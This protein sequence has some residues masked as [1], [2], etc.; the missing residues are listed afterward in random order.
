MYR[1]IGVLIPILFFALLVV[2]PNIEGGS[3]RGRDT[4]LDG[5]NIYDASSGIM[6][7]ML[8]A[9]WRVGISSEEIISMNLT[10]RGLIGKNLYNVTDIIY[11]MNSSSVYLY[12]IKNYPG[13]RFIYYAT[14]IGVSDYNVSGVQYRNITLGILRINYT[15]NISGWDAKPSSIEWVFTNTTTFRWDELYS[16]YYVAPRINFLKTVFLENK[17]YIIIYDIVR[18]AYNSTLDVIVKNTTLIAYRF[19]N[20]DTPIA[21]PI[22]KH[23][24]FLGFVTGITL[25]SYNNTPVMAYGEVRYVFRESVMALEYGIIIREGG[26]V[27]SIDMGDRYNPLE[28]GRAVVIPKNNTS[29]IVIGGIMK[30]I[31]EQKNMVVW[32]IARGT[33]GSRNIVLRV[34]TDDLAIE[35]KFGIGFEVSYPLVAYFGI[36]NICWSIFTMSADIEQHMA[37]LTVNYSNLDEF[38]LEIMEEEYISVANPTKLAGMDINNSALLL[39]FLERSEGDAKVAYINIGYDDGTSYP[40]QDYV[41]RNDV[42][43]FDYSLDTNAFMDTVG[44]MSERTPAGRM[45]YIA[46]AF[47]DDDYDGVG[48][49]EE[50]EIYGLDPNR[51]DFDGD[52]I[53]DG[54]EIYLYSTDPSSVDGDRDGLDDRFEIEVRPSIIYEEYNNTRNIYSTD[55]NNNDTDNDGLSDY[56]EIIGCGPNDHTTNPLK[57]DTDGDGIGDYE[58]VFVGI[59]YWINTTDNSYL[60]FSDPTEG[61]SDND[62][63]SDWEEKIFSTNPLSNDTDSDGVDDFRELNMFGTNVHICDGD[64]DGLRDGDE[65]YLYGTNPKNWDTDGD[66][67]S[68]GV[69]VSIYGTDPLSI[70]TD[71]DGLS[72]YEEVYLNI[73]PLDNDSDGDALS[74]YYEVIVVGTNASDKDSDSDGLGDYEEVSGIHIYGLGIVY[75]DPLNND[76][77][78]D[79]ITDYDECRILGT[80]PVSIDTDNDGI[81]DYDEIYSYNTSPTLMDTDSDN[82]TDFQEIRKYSTNPIVPDTDNDGLLDGEEILGVYI[83]NIGVR[84][85]DPLRG[86]TDGDGLTDYAE[87]KIYNTDPVKQDTDG[88]GLSD[89]AEV[90][91]SSDPLNPDTDGDGLLDGE[92]VYSYNTDPLKSDMDNDGLSD[93]EEVKI[94]GTDPRSRD[95]DADMIGDKYDILLPKTPDYIIILVILIALLTYRAYSYGSFRNWK[96]DILILGISD[97]GGTPM[98]MIPEDIKLSTDINLISSG[99]SGIIAMTSEIS[100]EKLQLL[101]LS[102]KV[103]I[104]ISRQ[105][106]TNM[107]I[108]IR[109]EY[110][111]IKKKIANIHRE[112]EGR[113]GERLSEW[114]GFVSETRDAKAWLETEL[115]YKPT[116]DEEIEEEQEGIDSIFARLDEELG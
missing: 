69:E 110:P 39:T 103:P 99:V 16:G 37:I 15:A 18:Y 58:E 92:E 112:L 90:E 70:D 104:I 19:E 66:G 73:N 46:I 84:K 42:S 79:G 64:S 9:G 13:T 111:R 89:P 106:N 86:D 108:F 94:R 32:I 1:Q 20:M 105:K 76:T 88:D 24:T 85:T 102:G 80:N 81:D 82:L 57:N 100:G 68:D 96:K 17:T 113:F 115:G 50:E 101:T 61:D 78:G 12:D 87:V 72:D 3:I 7:E 54:G 10:D 30:D 38:Y 67:L 51:S 95:S 63:L 49:W 4:Y 56:D 74:D 107:W 91:I 45:F 28:I 27:Y 47:H 55:P 2:N 65:I 29:D 5:R 40:P 59:S 34:V 41:F 52:G 83:G 109:K 77:D 35:R 11:S 33:P 44:M 60:V 116:R 114:G 22:W 21:E 36:E 71:Q 25:T 6:V 48:S 43:L 26:D 93:Y 97:S 98:F 14:L 23:G 31:L 75:P 53:N 8:D 62:G